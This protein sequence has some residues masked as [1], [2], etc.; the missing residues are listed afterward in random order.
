MMAGYQPLQSSFQSAD[1][2]FVP[3]RQRRTQIP[4]WRG[5]DELVQI[6]KTLVQAQAEKKCAQRC[7]ET[8]QEKTVPEKGR[9]GRE[10]KL[11][12]KQE[13]SKRAGSEHRKQDDKKKDA[14]PPR[15]PDY[16]YIPL[17]EQ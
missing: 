2:V 15:H 16:I 6:L 14:I 8:A 13:T 4:L 7:S 10:R 11:R 1:F 17:H 3:Y 9:T 5:S 12:K